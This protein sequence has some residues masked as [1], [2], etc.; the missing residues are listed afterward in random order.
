MLWL[1]TCEFI[2]RVVVRVL[3]SYRIY[4]QELVPREGAILFVCNHQSY[5][6][7][8]LCGIAPIDRP[9]RPLA[10]EGLFKLFPLGLILRSLGVL[11]LTG[12]ARDKS[13]IRI[14]LGE[15]EAGRTVLIF[16]EGSRCPDGAMMEFK[17]GV[18]LLLK[19]SKMKIVPMGIDGA[20]DA[21]P[22][23]KGIRLRRQIQCE[24]GTPIDSAELLKDGLRPAIARL[25]RDV[26]QLRMRCRERIRARTRGRQPAPGPGDTL[27]VDRHEPES[28]T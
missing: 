8:V 13:V 25:E 15:L 7:P 11:P 10:R 4:G 1:D 20:C 28:T 23:G 9:S 16:P 24:V 2:C 12:S 18:G 5:L 22:R 3:F 6:D 14:T 27:R 26:D 17:P 21:W 19:N